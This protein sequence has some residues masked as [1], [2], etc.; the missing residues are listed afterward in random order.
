MDS[1]TEKIDLAKVD[2]NNLTFDDYHKLN[3]QIISLNSNGKF[4]SPNEPKK[5]SGSKNKIVA[6]KISNVTY[7]I[8]ENLFIRLQQLKDGKNKADLIA[9]IKKDYSPVIEL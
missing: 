8:P 5:S 9:E 6:V 7:A 3:K 4:N 2:W 1:N